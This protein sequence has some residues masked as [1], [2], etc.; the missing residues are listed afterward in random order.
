MPAYQASPAGNA[1]VQ[2]LL[3][4]TPGYAYGSKAA[5]PTCLL[6]ITNVALTGN[7][8]TITVLVREGAIPIVGAL[9]TIKGT[10]NAAGAFNI[11]N[12]AITAVSIDSST[13]IGTITFALTHADVVSAAASGQGYVP[14]PEV[15]E[16]LAVGKS[17]QFAINGYGVSW[18][19]TCPSAPDTLAIQLEGAINDIDAEYTLIG[20]SQTTTTGYN[21]I[22]A[23]LPELVQFVR[24]HVT[25]TSG[26][27]LPTIIGKILNSA[28]NS[29]G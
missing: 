23:T 28:R 20:T 27:T 26:G 19:Y 2:L 3:P 21:E 18:A 10:A 13:G 9:I 25:A 17:K 12:S 6:Q 16:T 15:A 29:N 5:G 8:A 7:V 1:P 24:L 11:T 22:F 4:N 14:V